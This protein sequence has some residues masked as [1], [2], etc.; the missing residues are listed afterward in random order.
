MDANTFGTVLFIFGTLLAIAFVIG[1]VVSL[2]WVYR[3]AEHRG[4][5]GCMW[6]LIA[7]TS[8][9]WGVIAYYLLRDKQ[10]RL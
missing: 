5:T 3:D 2:V 9:P 4:K 7:F 1:W 10:V 8:W 6:L